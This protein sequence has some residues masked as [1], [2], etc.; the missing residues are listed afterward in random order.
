MIAN[1]ISP[2]S[3][4]LQMTSE[5]DIRNQTVGVLRSAQLLRQEIVLICSPRDHKHKLIQIVLEGVSLL[6]F[7]FLKICN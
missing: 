6:K 1:Q 7:K 4:A 5:D 3:Y 2:I